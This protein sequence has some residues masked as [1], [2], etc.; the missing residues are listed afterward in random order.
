MEKLEVDDLIWDIVGIPER[1][2]D[3]KL[4]Q[5]WRDIESPNL[6]TAMVFCI[7][8]TLRTAPIENLS[9]NQCRTILARCQGYVTI[10]DLPDTLLNQVN[11]N[12]DEES[13]QSPADVEF[14]FD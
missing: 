1:E 2:K 11:K 14:D 7:L 6:K 10:L 13:E 3:G 12:T 5:F 9:E 8:N 4:N